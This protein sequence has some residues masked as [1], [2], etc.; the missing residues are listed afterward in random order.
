M[1]KEQKLQ[2]LRQVFSPT[3][4]IKERDFFYGRISQL[5]KIAEAI[6]MEGQH[7]ILYGERGVGKTSL[8]NIIVKSF[9]NVYPVKVTCDRTDT[10]K[11]LWQRA[12]ENIKFSKTTSGIGFNAEETQQIVN[13]GNQIS[14][15]TNVRPSDIVN[16]LNNFGN[17]KMLFV[18]DEFD[19]IKS[20]KTKSLFA[21]LI[22][23]LS[24]N[25]LNSTVV[26]VGIADS[27]E[28]LIGDHQ[29]LERCLKQI[30]MPRMKKEESEEIINQGLKILEI[31]IENQV[32]EKI[33]DFSSGFPHYVHLLCEC[34]CKEIIKN[35]KNVFSETYLL[36]AIKSGIEN[37]SEQLRI[38]YRK[39]ILSS[40]NST[41][42]KDLLFACATAD[43]DEFNS[44][45]L[46]E[47]VKQYNKI[48]KG[49]CKNGG[50]SY[51]VNQL[52][53]EERGEILNKLGKGRSARYSFR[54][55]MMKAFVK[56]KIHLN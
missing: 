8:A 22:K 28:C 4:P 2:K 39:A 17:F 25:N 47:I 34:G 56:L 40:N 1:T 43:Y 37:T 54:N 13:M 10:F 50:V 12:F 38:A 33:V 46:K 19:N 36:I 42:W 51:N 20:D 55:P 11:S 14:S 7:A 30:K 49:N 29:S 31:R 44:F 45:T 35:D 9:T 48:T 3:S 18:F 27:I 52:L 32:R 23:S 53:T 26:L 5:E 6:N 41:K 15:I 24:D 21:D 16:L